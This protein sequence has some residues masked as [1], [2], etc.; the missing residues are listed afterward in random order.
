MRYRLNWLKDGRTRHFL[1]GETM[2]GEAL[3][4]AW[5]LLAETRPS[6]IWIE[7]EG[8]RR[9]ASYAD[10]VEEGPTFFA[11]PPD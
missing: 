10:I 4:F 7:T 2:P 8:G 6:D 5:T 9:V 11:P 3:K 1:K